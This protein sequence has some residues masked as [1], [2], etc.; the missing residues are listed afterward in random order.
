MVFDTKNISKCVSYPG[1]FG[2]SSILLTP[3]KKIDSEI[4]NLLNLESI[5]ISCNFSFS[6]TT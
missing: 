4:A 6:L 2:P 3:N 1:L 5:S